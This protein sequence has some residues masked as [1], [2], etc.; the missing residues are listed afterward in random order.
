MTHIIINKIDF[1]V[2]PEFSC[3]LLLIYKQFTVIIDCLF[4]DINQLK[5]FYFLL[6][7]TI[8]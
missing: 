8:F 5:Y 1:F 3:H 4:T 7:K 2:Q 6:D